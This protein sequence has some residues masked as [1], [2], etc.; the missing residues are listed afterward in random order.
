MG[1]NGSAVRRIHYSVNWRKLRAEETADWSR[2][3]GVTFTS[4]ADERR[5]RAL[6]PGMRSAVV[7]NAVDVEWFQP[8]LASPNGDRQTV[9]F[10]GIND[11]YPNTDAILFFIREVWPRLMSKHPELRLKIVG[12][13]P[14]REIVAQRSSRIEIAGAVDDVRPH[15]AQAAA[16]IVPLRLGGGTRFKVLEAL[17]MGRPVISTTIGA[18]GI[19]VEHGRHLLLADDPAEFAAAVTRVVGDAALAARLGETGRTLVNE[20]YSWTASARRLERFLRDVLAATGA[21]S[22]LGVRA[23]VQ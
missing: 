10:F 19:E 16:V 14:T 1:T 8:C 21:P 18:E 12:P 20:K 22:Q 4:H 2:F 6:V 3:D 13:R 5:A 17:A 9:M 7:P 15:L 23:T 11:Y